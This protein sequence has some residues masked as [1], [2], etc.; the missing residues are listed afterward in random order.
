MQVTFACCIVHSNGG[1]AGP[2]PQ[3][4][5]LVVFFFNH[6]AH[7]LCGRCGGL[8]GAGGWPGSAVTCTGGLFLWP[9]SADTL[10]ADVV[11]VIIL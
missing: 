6:L 10:L 11:V 4:L 7:L 5:A 8:N 9:T 2:D 3:E 1:S